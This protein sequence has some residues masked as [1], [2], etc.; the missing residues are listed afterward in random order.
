[1]WFEILLNGSLAMA[2]VWVS[3]V[4]GMAV[5]AKFKFSDVVG[6]ATSVCIL[7]TIGYLGF[8][9]SWLGYVFDSGHFLSGFRAILLASTFALLLKK[10]PSK[11]LVK[12]VLL[13]NIS[14]LVAIASALCRGIADQSQG[15]Q[16]TLAV[17]Y[18]NSVDNKIPGMFANGLEG[19]LPL[20]PEILEGWQSSDR[21]P[22]ATGLVRVFSPFTHSSQPDFFLLVASS[23][24]VI[25]I[26]I[27]FVRLIWNRRDMEIAI[28]LA[29]FLSPGIFVNVVYTWPK[30]I[31]ATLSLAA[32]IILFAVLE[33]KSGVVEVYLGLLAIVLAVLTHGSS[34]YAIPPV[35]ILF[36]LISRRRKILWVAAP[37][38]SIIYLPWFMYQQF[39]DPPGN[40]L[41]YWHLAG[42][43]EGS[44]NSILSVIWMSYRQLSLNQIIENKLHNFGAL[45]ARVDENPAVSGFSGILGPYRQLFSESVVASIGLLGWL[46]LCVFLFMALFRRNQF[47]SRFLG[48]IFCSV[49]PFCLIQFGDSFS[50]RTS[51]VVSPMWLSVGLAVV[52]Y[53]SLMHY[54]KIPAKV[55]IWLS[56]ANVLILGPMLPTAAAAGWGLELWDRG[57]SVFLAI[58]TLTL[59]T[60]AFSLVNQPQDDLSIAESSVI[61]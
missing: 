29:T 31:A 55:I 27:S 17:R 42:H 20:R 1:M 14:T 33:K 5:A 15:L 9:I 10:R 49:V 45:F 30:I 47:E 4:I 32:I 35:A 3:V 54:V 22:I 44:E 25:L 51:L 2:P 28:A 59:V 23:S 19:K 57:T 43:L 39:W 11:Y 7:G 60:I 40:R 12:I 50:T 21:P 52:A 41:I 46:G 61:K 37:F 26:V 13:C 36:F 8:L 53:A 38:V 16:H 18:W 48:L 24:M 58:C 6:I 34:V 56:M